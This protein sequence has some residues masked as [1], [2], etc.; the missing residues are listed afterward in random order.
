MEFVNGKDYPIYY[1]KRKMYKNVLNHQPAI[2]S[3]KKQ[4]PFNERT[5]EKLRPSSRAT[6]RLSAAHEFIPSGDDASPDGDLQNRKWVYY[7]PN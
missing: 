3:K 1:G 5:D 6:D 7:D 4:H 2:C